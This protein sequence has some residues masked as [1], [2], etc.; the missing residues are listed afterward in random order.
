[1]KAN[2]MNSIFLK[3]I[4]GHIMYKFFIQKSTL[5]GLKYDIILLR[6][7]FFLT[8]VLIDNVCPLFLLYSYNNF[9]YEKA[10]SINQVP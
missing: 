6:H 9:Y 3:V 10:T 5:S 8:Y 1:M 4:K 7:I 2:I